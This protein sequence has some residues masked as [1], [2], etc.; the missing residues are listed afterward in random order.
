M[1]LGELMYG[2]P[3][4]TAGTL[5]FF[6]DEDKEFVLMGL[7]FTERASNA[8]VSITAGPDAYRTTTLQ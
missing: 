3:E 5:N 2:L 1:F 4:E 8:M 6:A 7:V